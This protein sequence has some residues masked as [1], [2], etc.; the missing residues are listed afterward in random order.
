[1][2]SQSDFI[3]S[4]GLPASYKRDDKDRLGTDSGRKMCKPHS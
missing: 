4:L 1:M 2:A 3:Q